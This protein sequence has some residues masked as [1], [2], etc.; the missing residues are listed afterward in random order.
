MGILSDEI[1]ERLKTEL[2]ALPSAVEIVFFDDPDGN[3]RHCRETSELLDEVVA[4]AAG[5]I[6]VNRI[7]LPDDPESAQKY[8]IIGTPAIVIL[9]ED[10][11]DRGI[12]FYGIPG[13]HE[14]T[15]FVRAVNLVSTG[16]SGLSADTAESLTSLAKP[17]DVKVFV[18]L[19]CPYCPAA[20]EMAHKFAYESAGRVTASMIEAAGF[21]KLVSEHHVGRVP[22]IAIADKDYIEG[23][24]SETALL[25]R[26]MAAAK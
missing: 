2:A 26:I 23:A 17:V 14:F 25:E 3:C 10:R 11:R 22:K 6:R 21:M 13:G 7:S 20:V 24:P 9:D 5:K 15:S 16:V 19:A 8:A 4:R 18:T 12:R 1:L